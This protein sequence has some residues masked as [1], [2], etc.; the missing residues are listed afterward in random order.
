MR[1]TSQTTN[2]VVEKVGVFSTDTAVLCGI[3]A[4]ECLPLNLRQEIV[5]LLK[6]LRDNGCRLNDQFVPALRREVVPTQP[7][8]YTFISE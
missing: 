4:T 1:P 6:Q 8:I 5:I 7:K 3:S 2:R